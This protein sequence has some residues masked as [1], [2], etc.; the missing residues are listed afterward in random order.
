MNKTKES[1]IS[2]N[3]LDFIE[4]LEPLILDGLQIETVGSFKYL[5]TFIDSKLTFAG[6]VEYVFTKAIQNYI[7]LGGYNISV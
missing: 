6:N 2:R 4:G 1:V 7:L 3:K 5:G